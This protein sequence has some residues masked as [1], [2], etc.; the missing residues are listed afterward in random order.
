MKKFRATPLIIA[1][2]F[3]GGSGLSVTLWVK[4]RGAIRQDRAQA[5][6]VFER[7]ELL[8]Q[9]LSTREALSNHF[10]LRGITSTLLLSALIWSWARLKR[11]ALYQARSMN[12][13][14]YEK[15]RI[16]VMAQ[17]VA[18]IGLCTCDVRTGVITRSPEYLDL[19][20][21][22]TATSPQGNL[23]QLVHPDDKDESV[24]RLKRF[25][26]GE[27]NPPHMA[28][29]LVPGRGERIFLFEQ[30]ILQSDHGK[31]V[32]MLGVVQDI[33]HT[34]MT[35][36]A[37]RT[38]E[39]SLR[40]SQ[41]AI[42][43]AR[44]AIAFLNEEGDRIYVNDETCRLTGYPQ[45]ELLE[46]KI[47]QTFKRFTPE[48]YRKTWEQVKLH[49]T[50]VFETDIVTKNGAIVPVEAKASY[51]KFGER[52]MVFAL[53]RDITARRKT[54]Q[55]LRER[56]TQLRLL[57]FA[58]DHSQDFLTISDREGNRLYISEPFCRFSGYTREQL[59]PTKVWHFLPS[60]NQDRYTALW[61]DVKRC[62]TLV[63]EFELTIANGEKRPIEANATHLI[64]DGK[65]VICTISRDLS[66]RKAAEQE[67]RRIEQQ[68]QDTQKLESLGVL[69]GGIAHDFNNLLTGIL[70]NANLARD[71]LPP[72]APVHE[73]L[74][75]VERA[76]MRAAELCQQ[77]LAYAGKGR[78]LVGPINLSNLVK[79]TTQLLELS[80]SHRA[81]LELQLDPV[82][83]PIL[84]DATQI[85]QVVMNLV[86]NA[87][88][89]IAHPNGRITV[90]TS[91]E[92]IDAAFLSKARI[93]EAMVP[94]MAVTLEVSDNGTGMDEATMTRIFE[95]FFTT[96]FTGRGLGLAAVIG[97]VRSHHGALHV[98]STLGKGSR[99]YLAFSPTETAPT[100]KTRSPFIVT[101]L[102][103][104]NLGRVLI[105]DD[106]A[107][108]RQ[109]AS[110]ALER[111][112]YTVELAEDGEQAIAALKRNPTGYDV[113]LLD[114]V[115]PRLDGAQTL[116]EIHA[117]NPAAQVVLMSGFSEVEARERIGKSQ[118]AAFIQKP[119]DITILRR[120]VE[121]C[122]DRGKTSS[123]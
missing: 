16:L 48:S 118:L 45:Q 22:G 23:L 47:W 17:K 65:E 55:A 83:P 61:E 67:K 91:F 54:E 66:S 69:A 74:R 92:K 7:Q 57:E 35:E 104:K 123:V 10:L 79:D 99:F 95:P 82:I 87:A 102:K 26:R 100:P 21:M 2:V 53:A 89:A 76:S 33:T 101:N 77:M 12:R 30:S 6:D 25:I 117:I 9:Q 42:D 24:M 113:I 32:L 119:F 3:L 70:G 81:V 15:Q 116:R 78:F 36:Q 44:D 38:T 58:V 5:L 106:E 85:R 84:G 86:L 50:L 122:L 1:L 121:Q 60:L 41:F 51:F 49:G 93:A 107:N 43:H 64:Y 4:E 88:E 114:Y 18:R 40:L 8:A 27:T 112:G 72:D 94:G 120:A 11:E 63:F 75:Q 108:V 71:I 31:P 68:L 62:G 28:R 115:M 19:F 103:G 80:V 96:K 46:T 13:D 73:Q 29:I 37:L 110:M 20:G 109:V 14:L 90:R 97:I 56:E 39:N 111:A 98:E 52:E 34:K 59:L 105:V